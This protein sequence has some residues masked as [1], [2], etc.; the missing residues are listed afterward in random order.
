M[1]A[2]PLIVNVFID[3]CA[4]DPKYEPETSAS[5]EIFKLS[6]KVKFGLLIAHSTQK[7]IE[8][9]NTPAWVKQDA[10]GLIYSI[11]AQLTPN[12]EKLLCDI[13]MILAGNGK[14]ENIKQD[15][16]H[17]FEAQKYGCYFV[18]TDKRILVRA[19]ALKD[20]CGI[21]IQLPSEFL[22]LVKQY[23]ASGINDV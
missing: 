5:N 22:S 7:E 14:I 12:E 3:S 8:H 20:S 10:A 4:F 18:T 19:D 15:A 2:N 9:P 6:N 1:P 17:V 16:R 21:S 13:E 23:T 11:D